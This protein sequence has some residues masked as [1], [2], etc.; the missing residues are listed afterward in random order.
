MQNSIQTRK[1]KLLNSVSKSQKAFWN[2]TLIAIS[3]ILPHF[4]QIWSKEP[5][6]KYEG[7]GILIR[8]ENKSC[9]T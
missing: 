7:A 1:Q 2:L 3:P 5:L 9:L 8:P 6:D 4:N